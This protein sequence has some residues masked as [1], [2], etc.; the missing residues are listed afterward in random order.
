MLFML[1]V[2]F[3]VVVGV[4]LV[5]R[6][7]DVVTVSSP[8]SQGSI[9]SFSVE[10]EKVSF[11]LSGGG[12]YVLRAMVGGGVKLGGTRMDGQRAGMVSMKG[13]EMEC[14]YVYKGI[15]LKALEKDVYSVGEEVVPIRFDEGMEQKLVV[16]CQDGEGKNVSGK[17]KFEDSW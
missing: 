6:K 2:V 16:Y 13:D 3:V 1:T 14:R 9:E 4:W 12:E 7:L 8:V 11:W 10:E 5:Y 17:L 15:P